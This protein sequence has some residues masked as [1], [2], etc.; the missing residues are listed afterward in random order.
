MIRNTEVLG[1]RPVYGQ[2]GFGTKSF[3]SMRSVVARA[4]VQ[5]HSSSRL[6]SI[7]RRGNVILFR[8]FCRASRLGFLAKDAIAFPTAIK[9]A[10]IKI[11]DEIVVAKV[12][13]RRGPDET[14]D[15]LQ[16]ER[17]PICAGAQGKRVA[18]LT[19]EATFHG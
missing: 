7:L 16:Y 9:V 2:V 11:A 13:G 4:R 15:G 14:T 5:L 10:D 8:L 17:R 1:A 6:N 3:R 18:R 12:Q 19:G